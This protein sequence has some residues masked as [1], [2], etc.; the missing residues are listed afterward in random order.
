[1]RRQKSWV[2]PLAQYLDATLS[3]Q[4]GLSNSEAMDH[5]VIVRAEDIEK[6]NPQPLKGILV[7]ADETYTLE[8]RDVYP[9]RLMPREQIRPVP[10]Y[11]LTG[12][13]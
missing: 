6:V 8:H 7:I 5:I 10:A 3:D 9:Y 13:C 1:M 4:Y 12:N 2:L 11:H